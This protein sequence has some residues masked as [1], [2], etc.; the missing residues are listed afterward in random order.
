MQCS[1][2]LQAQPLSPGFRCAG[3]RA[4]LSVSAGLLGAEKAKTLRESAKQ[5]LA[6][7]RQDPALDLLIRTMIAQLEFFEKQL[8]EL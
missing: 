3:S 8:A 4:C 2:R 6:A 5:S 1:K 7:R